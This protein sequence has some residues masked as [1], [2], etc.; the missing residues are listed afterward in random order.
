VFAFRE[1]RGLDLAR[2][3]ALE[4]EKSA[5]Q[6]G[7]KIADR[8]IEVQILLEAVEEFSRRNMGGVRDITRTIERQITDGLIDARAGGA[9]A[10]RLVKDG[11]R[12][13]VVVASNTPGNGA[14]VSPE[15]T[16]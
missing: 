11:E 3:V 2:V 9:R 6:Y 5:G 13:K 15:P 14:P 10:V 7:L 1:L 4:I 12:V 16:A 8:G